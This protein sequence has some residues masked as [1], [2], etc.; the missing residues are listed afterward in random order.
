MLEVGIKHT[1]SETVNENNTAAALGSGLL[2]VYATPA[3]IALLEGTCAEAVAPQLEEGTTTVG[4]KL[5]VEHVSATPLGMEVKC[6]CELIEVDRRKLVFAVEIFD[7]A[8]L[9][10]KGKHERFIVAADKFMAKTNSKA[11]L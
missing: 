2:P 3:M 4:T 7:K 6:E 11:E 10:G 5:D 1:K 8:G 9:I